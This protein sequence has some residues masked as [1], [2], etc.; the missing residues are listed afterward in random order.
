M[1]EEILI[2]KKQMK[3]ME[4]LVQMEPGKRIQYEDLDTL[5][6]LQR[7]MQPSDLKDALQELL[8]VF[9][10]EADGE[11][12]LFG[13]GLSAW[14]KIKVLVESG[15]C[16][17]ETRSKRILLKE[18]G[19]QVEKLENII[20][21]SK[22]NLASA[23]G[24][25]QE[26]IRQTIWKN[27][28][29][30]DAVKKEQKRLK[31]ELERE[32]VSDTSLKRQ[33]LKQLE[34]ALRLEQ[35]QH[36]KTSCVEIPYYEKTLAF[37]KKY[38]CKDMAAYVLL[39][40]KN[41]IFFGLAKNAKKT[42]YDNQD[43]SL[44]ELTQAGE[45]FLQ[46][47]TE[48]LLGDEY[49]WKPLTAEEVRG[50]Q[51]YFDFVSYCF[52]K[53]LGDTLTAGEYMEFQRYYNQ[54]VASYFSLEEQ[55]IKEQMK[56]A[57]LVKKYRIYLSCYGISEKQSEDEMIQEI[58]V[59]NV[60]EYQDRLDQIFQIHAVEDCAKRQ[61]LTLRDALLMEEETE[62]PAQEKNRAQTEEMPDERKEE[63]A[64]QMRL[65]SGGKVFVNC[66]SKDG[67]IADEALFSADNL[68]LAVHDY[69]HRKAMQKT[70]GIYYGEYKIPIF[71]CKYG[72]VS[73]PCQADSRIGD[74]EKQIRDYYAE[75]M[76]ESMIQQIKGGNE[77]E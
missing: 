52:T 15:E 22:I 60:I 13:R 19:E 18:Y 40:R 8:E 41:S 57:F 43:E 73:V 44:L 70:I 66:Q 16:M 33:N 2:L 62:A 31:E 20:Q 28:V 6:I 54:L 17:F 75:L 46:F 65:L 42:R 24:Y 35:R 39:V 63:C 14:M 3:Q 32:Q 67:G 55:R 26:K 49:E 25:Q 37:S 51:Q 38:V 29:F 1:V 36:A 30:V 45:E 77:D 21:L 53:H 68:K 7:R 56:A 74:E 12:I 11:S 9:I 27:Q 48:N 50:M 23:E 71:I 61:I 64:D 58:L 4:E 5:M 34:E 47:M 72:G 59:H 10:E 69:L 76:Q